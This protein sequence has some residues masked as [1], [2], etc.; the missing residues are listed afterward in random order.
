MY[1]AF[2]ALALRVAKDLLMRFRGYFG[3]RR[4]PAHAA[5]IHVRILGVAKDKKCQKNLKNIS[6]IFQ[7]YPKLFIYIYIS[8]GFI[9][10]S[11]TS[12]HTRTGVRS[13]RDLDAPKRAWDAPTPKKRMLGPTPRVVFSKLISL[14]KK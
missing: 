11:R 5:R 7:K 6:I 12:T 1:M 8:V 9:W 13:R 3:G 2:S 14:C 10:I 4:K